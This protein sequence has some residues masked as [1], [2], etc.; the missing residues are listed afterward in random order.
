MS[1]AVHFVSFGTD[2][3]ECRELRASAALRGIKVQVKGT[4]QAW[5]GFHRKLMATQEFAERVQRAHGPDAVV[6]FL[7]AYDVLFADSAESILRKYRSFGKP[8]VVSAEQFPHP[9]R[10]VPRVEGTHG[11][12]NSG[13]YIGTAA[14]VLH[15]LAWARRKGGSL[16]R[17]PKL[18]SRR[19]PNVCDDQRCM[20]AYF[21][22]HRDRC[23]LDTE[24]RIFSCMAGCSPSVLEFAEDGTVFNKKSAEQTSV[25]HLNGRSKR[26]KQRMLLRLAGGRPLKPLSS[27]PHKL[28]QGTR[29][30]KP[31]RRR[32]VT[33]W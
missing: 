9:D 29:K 7:D 15:F 25:I 16:Y 14:A 22:T 12:C 3:R 20:T 6:C 18:G 5:T 8:L 13:T 21:H 17:T 23:A 28:L 2:P 30:R 24:Q 27:K 33:V 26:H 31:Q 19:K 32:L 10:G 1:A 4:R 11:Y